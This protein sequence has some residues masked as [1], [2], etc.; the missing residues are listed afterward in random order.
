MANIYGCA[1]KKGFF[2]SVACL[3]F[4]LLNPYVLSN[5][6]ANIFEEI[7][8][9]ILK[10]AWEH[11]KENNPY[12]A[13]DVLS[14]YKPDKES[15][16]MYYF[17]YG[18]ALRM[19][20]KL[21][22]AIEKLTLSYI[23]SKGPL[24]ESALF[25]RANVYFERGYYYES[26]MNFRIFI[27][28]FPNSDYIKQAYKGLARSLSKIGMHRDA[29]KYFE[30]AGDD[31]DVLVE[32]ANTLY[33]IGMIREAYEIYKI[34]L[35]KDSEFIKRYDDGLY[36]LGDTLR[37]MNNYAEAKRYLA[38]IKDN[39][40]KYNASISLGLIALNESNFDSA[41]KF[42]NQ[43]LF[44]RD[45]KIKKESLFYLSDVNIR[46]KKID[47]AISNLEEI[48]LKYPYGKDYFESLLR[49][50]ELYSQKEDFKKSLAILKEIIFSPS[51]LKKE[52]IDNLSRIMVSMVE[53]DKSLFYESWKSVGRWLFDISKE[54]ALFKIAETLQGND[55]MS[56]LDIHLWLS[57]NG[58]DN[59]KTKSL[60]Y[61]ANFYLDIGEIKKTEEYLEALKKMKVSGDDLKRV[62]SKIYYVKKDYGSSVD[63]LLSLSNPDEKDIKMIGR[64][65][66]YAKDFKRVLQVY[67][68]T[69][70]SIN[71]D[72]TVYIHLADLFY[73]NNRM[74]DA[75]NYYRLAVS[76]NPS[77][78]WAIYRI[79]TIAQNN[80]TKEFLKKINKDPVL[81]NLSNIK[82]KEFDL[83][84][85]IKEIF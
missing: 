3:I 31:L 32:K 82:I 5:S 63:I 24:K 52:A 12:E 73:E 19:T 60:I 65:I 14:D 81:A 68:K 76:I 75:L 41:M 21:P 71:A 62:E 25:E 18:K 83:D 77:N 46:L 34:V 61:L 85:K 4:F 49:L 51:S 66:K 26:M 28:E 37:L 70:K 64:L 30:F 47:K 15:L 79:S 43:A 22:I 10:K 38:L 11:L 27:K 50:S 20:K 69:I 59:I 56:A 40:F 44:S 84:K 39:N 29:L 35:A 1:S 48:R 67:E 8:S 36:C 72:E 53:K 2:W 80:E 13:I 57:K 33:R 17:L 6:S 54:N 45:R 16:P 78:E 74:N 42:F 23:Y 55:E 58:S 7:N 9:P